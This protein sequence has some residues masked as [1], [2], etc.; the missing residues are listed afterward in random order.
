MCPS[1]QIHN[2]VRLWP[3]AC[4]RISRHLSH[5]FWFAKFWPTLYLNKQPHKSYSDC[6]CPKDVNTKCCSQRK[7]SRDSMCLQFSLCL[8]CNCD[9]ISL[10]CQYSRPMKKRKWSMT[11]KNIFSTQ[12]VTL[13]L[14]V[15][16]HAEDHNNINLFLQNFFWLEIIYW[17]NSNN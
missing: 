11:N 6:H 9:S 17:Y 13:Y 15:L 1:P 16:Q 10:L 8:L 14:H 5:T 3:D 12:Q 7:L 2:Q 4:T